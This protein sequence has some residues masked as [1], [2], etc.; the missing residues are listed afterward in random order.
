[1]VD[2]KYPGITDKISSFVE[3]VARGPIVTMTKDY[4]NRSE[5]VKQFL[6]NF[7]TIVKMELKFLDIIKD[8]GLSF[9]MLGLI[10][11]PKA[12]MDLP[13][14]FGSVI[15]MVMF[16][17]IFIP[18]LCSSL[19]LAVNNFNMFLPENS[20]KNSK[21]R[22]CL[23]TAILFLVSPIVPVFLE[24]HYLKCSEEARKLAQEY[25]IKAIQKKQECRK[26]KRQLIS[27]HR[28]ELGTQ[29]NITRA[30]NF[31]AS[32]YVHYLFV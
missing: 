9:L 2:V 5:K 21:I 3:T 16:A 23:K 6:E 28:I 29:S 32:M 17:S 7:F 11:G 30:L 20:S 19:H 18:M 10:G 15:V 27:F 13:N 1:M 22:R 24:T 8:L 14:N 31:T 26:I 12:I 4:I 25:N